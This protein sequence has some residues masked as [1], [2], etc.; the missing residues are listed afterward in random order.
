MTTEA[1][2]LLRRSKEAERR[3][4]KWLIANNGPDPILRPGGGIVSETGRVGHITE[5]QFDLL[6]RDYAGEVKNIIVWS[7]LWG[8]WKKVVD[9]AADHGKQ[10][11][12]LIDYANEDKFVN[13]KR[14]PNLHI[15]SEER[16]AELLGYEKLYREQMEAVKPKPGAVRSYSKEDQLRRG[17]RRGKA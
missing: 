8:F 7:T 11:L 10:P 9:K 15:I 12:L 13:G 4:G 14:V 16:H 17:R 6:S 2:R 1:Q 5:L 3:A